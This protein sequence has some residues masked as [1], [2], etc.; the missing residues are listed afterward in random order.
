[1]NERQVAGRRHGDPRCDGLAEI[2][3][4]EE[5]TRSRRRSDDRDAVAQPLDR[6]GRPAERAVLG[7]ELMGVVEADAL[8]DDP[9][10]AGEPRLVAAARVDLDRVVQRSGV[11]EHD[12]RVAGQA[13]GDP[14]ADVLAGVGRRDEL[15]RRRCRTDDGDAVAQPLV[16]ERRGRASCL[17]AAG[18]GGRRGEERVGRGHADGH[19]RRHS[20][21][22]KRADE[23]LQR[24]GR[25]RVGRDVRDVADLARG[26]LHRDLLAEICRLQE[27][28]RAGA[29]R[30]RRDGDPVAVPLELLARAGDRRAVGI[31]ERGH[32]RSQLGADGERGV[33]VHIGPG[34]RVERQVG[35]RGIVHHL[36]VGDRAHWRLA[37][38]DAHRDLLAA[39]GLSQGVLRGGRA[40]DGDA[41]AQPLVRDDDRAP[42]R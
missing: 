34:A 38:R 22:E 3:G 39:V 14:H 42:A 27:V 16:G 24:R 5:V 4:D 40:D 18:D 9:A 1:M 15:V 21:A 28:A 30:G 25:R 13:R 32:R 10:A 37:R 20:G 26:D 31:G 41:V 23:H 7:Q 33:D 36:R 11:R 8:A 2:G 35:G 6:H 12:R 29:A 17:D 19:R